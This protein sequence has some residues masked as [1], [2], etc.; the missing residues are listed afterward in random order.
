VSSGHSDFGPFGRRIRD[1]SLPGPGVLSQLRKAAVE[2]APGLPQL[3]LPLRRL[4]P[5]LPAE[6]SQL[7]TFEGFPADEFV[8]SVG[9]EVFVKGLLVRATD[10]IYHLYAMGTGNPPTGY[11]RFKQSFH[12]ARS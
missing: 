5:G 12:L 6:A 11:D 1:G 3:R 4:L 8:V 2:L 9:P 7:T 10:R